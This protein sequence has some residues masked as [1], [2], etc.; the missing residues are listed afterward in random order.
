LTPRGYPWPSL[1][2]HLPA[3]AL[4][5][6]VGGSP[7]TGV[8]VFHV[9]PNVI[10]RLFGSV[11]A[12][13][14]LQA[15]IDRDMKPGSF[16]L[17]GTTATLNVT[18]ATTAAFTQNVV[19]VIRGSDRL[20]KDE[21]VILGAHYDH[22][23]VRKGAA[24]DEDSIFNGADDN[25]SG[26]VAVMGVARAMASADPKPRRSVLVIAFAGEEKGFWGSQYYADNPLVPLENTVAML[27]LD[28]VARNDP[29]SLMI[30]DFSGG[31]ELGRIT[32]AQNRRVGFRL[33]EP[34]QGSGGSDH[35]SFI[36]RGVPAIWYFSGFHGDLHDVTDEPVHLDLRKLARVSQLAF[37]TAWQLANDTTHF[38]LHTIQ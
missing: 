9:G 17:H 24:A 11:E 13:R 15:S 20:L 3:D 31:K 25:A 6:I 19:G 28:M 33:A 5:T 7:E 27:N 30:F 12:L 21:F 38:T 2:D 26:T 8:P 29:D 10:A 37:L 1:Y 34:T 23:G 32:R 14:E 22:I 16:E 18:T 36:R 4:P 35:L